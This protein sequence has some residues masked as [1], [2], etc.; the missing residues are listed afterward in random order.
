[1]ANSVGVIHSN[2]KIFGFGFHIQNLEP[3]FLFYFKIFDFEMNSFSMKNL[4]VLFKID[5]FSN[6]SILKEKPLN[7]S[8]ND[9]KK[10]GF[11]THIFGVL[12]MGMK[13]KSKNFWVIVCWG[14]CDFLR[15]YPVLDCLSLNFR[16]TG[17][18]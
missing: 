3:T 4:S 10:F 5:F 15:D 1:M 17:I 7:N 14:Y 11:H 6:S 12:G 2:P 9:K 13:L 8:K 18:T 16:K